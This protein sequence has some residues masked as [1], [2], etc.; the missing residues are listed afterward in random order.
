MIVQQDDTTNLRSRSNLPAAAALQVQQ[1]RFQSIIKRS[2]DVLLAAIGLVVLSPLLLLAA[3]LVKC[4]SPGP[5]FFRQERMGLRFAPFR[6]YKFRTMVQDAPAKGPSITVG[7]D[8]RI[9]TVGRLLR[10]MKIDELPQLVNVLRGEM[11][12]VGPRPEV[13]KYVEM[14]REDYELILQMR[15]GITDLASIKYRHEAA[16]LA[17]AADPEYEYVTRV[18]PEKI[19]LAKEYLTRAS[20]LFDLRLIVKTLLRIV[21]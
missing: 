3:L 20:L 21:H 16:I 14:F 6:I 5:I 18:L 10:A 7:Q 17:H 1:R 11:S 19:A 4:S 15:P 2:F 12:F 8:S 9:T 13:S